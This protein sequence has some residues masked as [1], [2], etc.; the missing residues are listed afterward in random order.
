LVITTVRNLRAHAIYFVYSRA[1]VD[2]N[3]LL[4]LEKARISLND[5]EI[6]TSLN[7]EDIGNI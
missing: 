3:E 2:V 4:S 5:E 1:E 6:R 7:K